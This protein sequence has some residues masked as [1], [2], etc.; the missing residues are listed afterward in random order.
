MKWACWEG[1][2]VVVAAGPLG[3][4]RGADTTEQLRTEKRQTVFYGTSSN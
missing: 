1:Q 2:W 3:D 4:S